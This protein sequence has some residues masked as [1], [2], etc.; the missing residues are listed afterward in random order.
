MK[1]SFVR[2]VIPSADYKELEEKNGRWIVRIKEEEQQ[3]PAQPSPDGEGAES[4]A[5]T[6]YVCAETSCTEE[7]QL[8]VVRSEYN[9][10][11]EAQKAR[12]LERAK[13]AKV[14][15]I[16]AYDLSSD[17]NS[18]ALN[19]KS[20]WLDKA[21]R[22]GL[23]NSTTIQKEAGETETVLWFDGVSYT[24]PV[25]TT[26]KMLA[27]LELYALECYNVTAKHK[28][29]VARL[30]TIEEV[31]AYDITAGYPAKLEMGCY[32]VSSDGSDSSDKSE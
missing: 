8:E 18:F 4:A 7:P 1:Y 19:A 32:L 10:W 29:E 15:E 23:V 9:A 14:A 13:A 28:A 30:A 31:E 24:L 21:M 20:L 11:L 5:Q 12:Q 17:V 16:V 25:D 3:A 26:L 2:T 22:V 27:A 6:M